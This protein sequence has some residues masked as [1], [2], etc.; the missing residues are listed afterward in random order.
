[1]NGLSFFLGSSDTSQFQGINGYYW[2][3]RVYTKS[4][5]FKISNSDLSSSSTTFIEGITT[6]FLDSIS[7]LEK[8]YPDVNYA[9]A[10]DS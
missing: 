10:Q 6:A 8:F 2:G 3:P 7:V 9:P 5:A 1:M 4:G